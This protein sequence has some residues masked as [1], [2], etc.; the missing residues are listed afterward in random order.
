MRFYS[1]R[2]VIFV[3]II[4]FMLCLTIITLFDKA[5]VMAA[6]MLSVCA[7]FI[8][9]WFDTYY[10]IEDSKLFSDRRF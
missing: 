9:M 8:W 4:G 6:I 2:G 5:Y 7:Y 1:K 3:I 10:I